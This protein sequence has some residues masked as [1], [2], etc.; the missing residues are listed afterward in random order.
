M[1]CR[2]FLNNFSTSIS[3]FRSQV[4][5]CFDF[6]RF[7]VARGYHSFLFLY[8]PLSYLR[9]NVCAALSLALA[10]P[11][12]S[13]LLL[14]RAAAQPHSLSNHLFSVRFYHI[15]FFSTTV[16]SSAL[17]YIPIDRSLLNIILCYALH[18]LYCINFLLG[19][20]SVNVCTKLLFYGLT[21]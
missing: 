6:D 17:K 4:S 3:F 11:D 16:T 15:Y 9:N 21:E 5:L 19:H 12:D 1:K 14:S 2:I 18:N 8:F 13:P 10:S 7:V 20:F